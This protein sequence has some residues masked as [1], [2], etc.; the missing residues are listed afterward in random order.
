MLN[1]YRA[2]AG[3]G[4]TFQL[5][6]NYI[7]LLFDAF[8][9]TDHP[10]RRI[11]A[12]TFTNKATDEMKS[13]ILM[14]LHSLYRGEKSDYR[15][16]LTKKYL[17]D[18]A[19]VNL[20]AGKILI[21]IL[22]DYSSFSIST[23]DKFFQQVIRTFAR[24]IGVNGGYNLELDTETTL[25]QAVD[26][27]FLE[28][29]GD[30][31]KQ[32]LDWLT[33]FAEEQVEQSA[34][35]NIQK[36]IIKLGKEIFKENF[37]HKAEETSIKLHDKHYLN[38][39]L[40]KLRR[41]KSGFEKKVTDEADTTLH[42]LEIHGL[43]PD[44][45][46][47][48]MM[49]KTLNDLKNGNYEVKSTFQ[50]YAENPENCYTKAQKPHI[51]AAIETAFHS[52]L[53]SQL[54][55]ILELVQTEIIHYNTANLILKH[56]NTLGIM[57]DLAMQIKKITSDQNIMLISD[58][59]LLL[60]K[61]IDN[62]DTPF[63]YERTGLNINHFMI[64]EFQD[65]SVLQWKNFKPLISNS[66][67]A[68]NYN[69]VVGDVKQSI[70]RWRNSDWKLLDE[71]VEHDFASDRLRTESLTTNWRSDKNIIEFNNAFF[72][73]AAK[74]LQI[75]LNENLDQVNSADS[76]LEALRHR[77]IH[78]YSD[79]NQQ[80]SPKAAEG[81]VKFEFIAQDENEEGWKKESLNRI[82]ALLEDLADRGYKPSDVAF[83]VRKNSEEAEIINYLLSY[84][85][86]GNAREGYSYDIVGNE[87]LMLA[88]SA[89]VNFILAVLKLM[90][91]PNDSVQRTIL[92]YEYL[93]G[94]RQQ[95]ESSAIAGCFDSA[96]N[97]PVFS[98][99]FSTEENEFLARSRQN[100]LYNLV[101]NLIEVFGI[102]QWHQETV[103]LQAFQDV[104]FKFVN[105]RN[106]DLNSFL[107][108][109][110]NNGASQ[111]IATPENQNSFR[112]MTIHKSK[113]L[114]F[115][116]VIMPF[117]DW[118]LD[119]AKNPPLLWCQTDVE[120]Y[121]E[122][123]LLPI[124]YSSRL[125]NS[126]FQKEYFNEQMHQYIDNL[127]MAYVA[128]TRARNELICFAPQSKNEVPIEIAKMASLSQLI[129]NGISLDQTTDTNQISL[130]ENY[131]P[132]TNS[133]EIGKPCNAIYTVKPAESEMRQM[134][135]Y[136]IS[137]SRNR[138]RIKH[139]DRDYWLTG[140]HLTDSRL[141][142]GT[143]MHEILKK[144]VTRSDE[145]KAI[146]EMIVSG[147]ITEQESEMIRTEMTKFWN[148]PETTAWF[149]PHAKILNET[150]ILLPT[151]EQ[152]RPD[153]LILR[154][155]KAI[156]VD[157]KFG[158]EIKKSHTLQV[159]SYENIIRQMGYKTETYLCYVSLNKVVSLS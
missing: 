23:I 47:R 82:P 127:N 29:S 158:D 54:D 30:D 108:W 15:A 99:L 2:S 155:N 19:N 56:I 119:A 9:N 8:K 80:I 73:Q 123:P 138:L 89:S 140:Q 3:S 75:K 7:F 77:I 106:A 145:D 92:N 100:S 22:H 21:H 118:F 142:Y 68:N 65:T 86:S 71:E 133:F 14:E 84:K 39:Y 93:R 98:T 147:K 104:I 70:Y 90:A 45:F 40:Q 37:Q 146:N 28:L 31:N 78:A 63:V 67:A 13:R 139:S 135:D 57:S 105:S 42:L 43:E 34:N 136:P 24:E 44:Y 154:D 85:N 61:I 153:R 159:A 50:N 152:Y 16:E 122:F 115:K 150:S 102:Q 17:Q 96:V 151:G 94:R 132:E 110:E 62:S 25:Q 46:S 20:Q 38:E 72:T 117:C 12:V 91:N 101:E 129:L 60:N 48:K 55:K 51:K 116:V 124:D 131:S 27:L 130:A 53:K 109:W 83:L 76:E 1:I 58:T 148:M 6:K 144:I 41:I 36:E 121:N 81:H 69:M 156:I 88:S 125:V 79:V 111:S 157:Y 107:I 97:I 137:D 18:E 4:K 52:G 5:T 74:L 33:R 120:P 113:G 11:M 59:N 10:H 49:H 66:V 112:I 149:D 128:F 87:G 126:I 32:L 143:I 64:D 26:N 114:D 141:N 35:W 95:N 103:F 134:K